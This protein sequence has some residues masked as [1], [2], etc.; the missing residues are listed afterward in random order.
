MNKTR[1]I[2]GIL[3]F[4]SLWGFSECVV[5]NLFN[6]AGLPTAE[7]MVGFFAITFLLLSRIYFHQPGMQIGMGLIAGTLRLFNPMGCHLCSAVA[8]VAE[9]AIFELIWYR[10]SFDLR[11]LKTITMQVSMG[12]ISAYFVFI[13]GYIITQVLSP[14]IAGTGFFIENLIF[15]IPNILAGGVIPALIGGFVV[16]TVL[17]A[18]RLDLTI[19]DRI[20]YPTTLGIS[21]LCWI[22]VVGNWLLA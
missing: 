7:L 9:G 10:L 1:L 19:K 6:D 17:L 20:Y 11:E 5:G 2:L 21:A 14:I 15:I 16:P 22:I 8:I 12:I 18:K 3:I 4:G 13:F